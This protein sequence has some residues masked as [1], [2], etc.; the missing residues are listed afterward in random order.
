MQRNIDTSDDHLTAGDILYKF[1]HESLV[2]KSKHELIS[3]FQSINQVCELKVIRKLLN[4][5]T[6]TSKNEIPYHNEIFAKNSIKLAVRSSNYEQPGILSS[7][8]AKSRRKLADM[9]NNS[10][11]NGKLKIKVK[12]E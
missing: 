4:S 6:N 11:E 7:K 3:A 2:N 9:L 10:D 1:N 5:N 8:R 12:Y